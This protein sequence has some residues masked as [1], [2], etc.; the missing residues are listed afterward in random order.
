MWACRVDSRCSSR[1]LGAVGDAIE[2]VATSEK[3]RSVA[4][5]HGLPAIFLLRPFAFRT[6]F[7]AVGHHLRL[8]PVLC[9]RQAAPIR[10]VSTRVIAVQV[11]VENAG[12]TLSPAWAIIERMSAIELEMDIV[13]RQRRQAMPF[14]RLDRSSCSHSPAQNAVGD[15][16]PL[17]PAAL[18]RPDLRG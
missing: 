1:R 11:G 5:M 12:S 13:G 4:R 6:K 8:E 9:L 3:A 18:A 15:V 7:F 14:D 16:T 17:L 2:V 10:V